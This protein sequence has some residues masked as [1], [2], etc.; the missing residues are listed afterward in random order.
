MNASTSENLDLWY[1]KLP[2]GDVHRVTLDQ[3]DGAFQGGRID[4]R[5]MVM[6]ANADAGTS[7]TSL[8]QLLGL[9]DEVPAA[10][11]PVSIPVA[12]PL[13]A[14]T[15]VA[16][17]AP[18]RFVAAAPSVA[19]RAYASVAPMSATPPPVAYG[20]VQ[21]PV[22]NSLRPMSFDLDA[23]DTDDIHYPRSSR[24]GR[25]VAVVGLAAAAG[26][27]G[28]MST[29]PRSGGG[30]DIATVAAAAA[31]AAPQSYAAAPLPPP[32]APQPVPYVTPTPAPAAP[33][34]A[35]AEASP[36]NP[37]FTSRFNE[38]TKLKLMAAD[39]A[40]EDKAKARQAAA[41]T[42]H[43]SSHSKSST[44]FTS[45]GNKYDPLNSNL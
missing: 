8:S 39:Q 4:G 18:V 31:M 10:Q 23:S 41:S 32:A 30:D 21:A 29:H 40:R 14:P 12:A 15:P 9:E 33:G 7:W 25:V 35:P 34:A 45:G 1:V 37:Q 2:N 24:K 27:A 20:R 36:M 44:V 3:L 22:G 42:Y 6:P 5:T 43:P 28:F 19:P 16:M 13:V 26:V 17:V 11:P 38:A